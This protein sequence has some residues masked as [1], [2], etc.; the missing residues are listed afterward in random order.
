[1]KP[2]TVLFLGY[3]KVDFV[4]NTSFI[5]IRYT[6]A[7]KMFA[8]LYTFEDFTSILWSHA[9]YTCAS[10]SV[11]IYTYTK[12]QETK[13]LKHIWEICEGAPCLVSQTYILMVSANIQLVFFLHS[14][15]NWWDA[16]LNSSF[17][18][19]AIL[20]L[21]LY[22]FLNS[23]KTYFLSWARH[24]NSALV[25]VRVIFGHWKTCILFTPFSEHI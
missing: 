15:W 1:M 22:Q 9:D 19:C 10:I 11:Y 7:L 13:V 23:S 21:K 25:H 6:R 2:E 24:E 14:L 17:Q 8:S 5:N 12:L 18:W 4:S 20:T 16:S 3:V